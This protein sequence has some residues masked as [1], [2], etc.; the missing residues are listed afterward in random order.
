MASKLKPKSMPLTVSLLSSGSTTLYD[1]TVCV[2]VLA[3]ND[4]AAA[5]SLSA[6]LR[7]PTSLGTVTFSPLGA[8]TR[9][10]WIGTQVVHPAPPVRSERTDP[11]T[12]R[13][14]RR[15]LPLYV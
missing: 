5:A 2:A 8:S 7:P 3:G 12:T 9:Y 6:G 15:A 4:V 14:R 13:M 11:F 1:W 10:V